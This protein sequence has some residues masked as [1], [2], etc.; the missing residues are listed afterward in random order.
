MKEL[1]VNGTQEFMGKEIKVIEGGFGEDCKVVLARDIAI[2]HNL[3]LKDVNRNIKRLKKKCRIKEN[4]HFIDLKESVTD[5]NPLFTE[6]FDSEFLRKSANIFVL[7]ERGYMS[8]CRHP[9]A[10]S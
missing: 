3:D 10:Q 4:I 9:S 1:K 2:I 8:R 7:S 5:S 6:L